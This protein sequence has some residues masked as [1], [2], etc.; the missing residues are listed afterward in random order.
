MVQLR[1]PNNFGGKLSFIL[2]FLFLERLH[3]LHCCYIYFR[4]CYSRTLCIKRLSF[5]VS[6]RVS[7]ISHCDLIKCEHKKEKKKKKKKKKKRGRGQRA[8][9]GQFGTLP[10]LPEYAVGHGMSKSHPTPLLPHY[11]ANC[12]CC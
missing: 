6:Y 11:N 12:C 4:C 2:S 3:R 9:F 10:Y 5:S 8:G 7:S 1:K